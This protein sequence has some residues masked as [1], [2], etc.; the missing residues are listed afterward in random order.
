MTGAPVWSAFVKVATGI[1]GPPRPSLAWALARRREMLIYS[2]RIEIGDW[3]LRHAD[4]TNATLYETQRGVKNRVLE[5]I[6]PE[7]TVQI[8]FNPGKSPDGQLP[9]PVKKAEFP[10]AMA[11][12]RIVF[13]LL[14]LGALVRLALN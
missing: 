5:I 8:N 10:R 6:T 13:W 4:V 9:Y 1:S 11:V 7:R 2:D 14:L 3:I 12:F